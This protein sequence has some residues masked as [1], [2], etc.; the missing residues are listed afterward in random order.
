MFDIY[1]RFYGL[2]GNNS[3]M[4]PGNMG[5]DTALLREVSNFNN[6]WDGKA[7]SWTWS[8]ETLVGGENIIETS[9]HLFLCGKFACFVH[10]NSF[11]SV[12]TAVNRRG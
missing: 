12:E 5:V 3:F 1:V 4:A 6:K 7:V 10:E 8:A 2:K 9:R 11:F